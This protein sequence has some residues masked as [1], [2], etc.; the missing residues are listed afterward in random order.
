MEQN[1]LMNIKI[2]KLFTCGLGSYQLLF[3]QE[4][5]RTI[6]NQLLMKITEK[7]GSSMHSRHYTLPVVIYKKDDKTQQKQ[8]NHSLS[9]IHLLI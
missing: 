8:E 2:V 9:P 6:S 5:F 1:R 4:Q 3:V 7:H